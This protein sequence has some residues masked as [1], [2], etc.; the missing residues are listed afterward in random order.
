MSAVRLTT[1]ELLAADLVVVGIGVTPATGW[2]EGSGLT[3]HERDRG[4]VCDATLATGAPGV[5]AAGDVAHVPNP[6]FDDD[7][8][9][10]EHWT[11]AAEQGAAAARH[12]VDPSAARPLGSVPYFWSDWYSAGSSS[13]APLVPT[14]SPW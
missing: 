2:L 8:M 6:L 7:L 12:A 11:N 13:W 10:L 5:Y 14:R 4:V 3:L 9:R 1:G